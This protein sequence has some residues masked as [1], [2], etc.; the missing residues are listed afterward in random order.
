MFI[1]GYTIAEKEG[2]IKID[3]KNDL[4]KLVPERARSYWR[5]RMPK[6]T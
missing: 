4:K 1:T 3:N 5:V 2:P 6:K